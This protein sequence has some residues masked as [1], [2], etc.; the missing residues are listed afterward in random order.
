MYGQFVTMFKYTT[1][2]LK[3][4]E[5]LLE[6]GGFIIRYERGNFQAG[7]CILEHK[8]VVVVNKYYTTEAR[9]NCL[10]D[11]LQDVEIDME[12]LDDKQRDFLKKVRA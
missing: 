4:L 8:R 2:T 9:I 3:K 10:V 11:I 1:H 6:A 5:A 7:Y 12:A